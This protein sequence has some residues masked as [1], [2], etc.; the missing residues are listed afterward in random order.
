MISIGEG[1]SEFVKAEAKSNGIIHPVV[2][3][4]DCGCIMNSESVEIDIREGGTEKGFDASVNQD[5]VRFF[6]HPRVMHLA[7]GGSIE[8]VTYATGRYKKLVFFPKGKK[9]NVK[10]S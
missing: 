9:K 7:E 3:L 10:K 5:G 8:V 6:V 1:V 4:M 2:F